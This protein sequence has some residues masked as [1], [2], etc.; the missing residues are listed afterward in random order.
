M[1]QV[2]KYTSIILLLVVSVFGCQKKEGD[3]AHSA[4]SGQMY[5][6]PMHPQIT[7]PKPGSCPIC[8]MDLVAVSQT[9]SEA[10]I[11]LSSNQMKLANIQTQAVSSSSIGN[12]TLLTATTVANGNLRVQISSRVSG[13][14]EKLYVKQVGEQIKKGTPLYDLYSEAL[15]TLQGEYLLAFTQQK[16]LGDTDENYNRILQA[17]KE[18]LLLYGMSEKQIKELGNQGKIKSAVTFFSNEA[19]IVEE[20]AISEGQYIAEGN[21][22][23]TVTDLSSLWV[24]AQLY[25]AE[26]PL[27]KIGAT[28]DVRMSGY[29]N[30]F[31]KGKVVF[32]APELETNSKIILMRVQIDNP[33]LKYIPGMQASVTL[34]RDAEKALTLPLNAVIRD[35]QGSYVWQQTGEGTFSPVMVKLGL[36]NASTVEVI[37]GISEGDTI[38][39][40]GAYLLHSEY[41][42][43]KGGNPMAGHDHSGMNM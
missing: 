2:I 22:I 29:E 8:G 11:M 35:E 23:I 37:A 10:G 26:L 32:L 40:S 18:K 41:I 6:C 20:I 36:E 9:Q 28:V 3:A 38:V 34:T 15:L 12:N 4:H 25:P 27:V 14:I 24:E 17:A 31:V 16:A 43:K 39:V 30:E 13:R 19:G 1:D 5:T 7:E 21:P 42:L 33:G